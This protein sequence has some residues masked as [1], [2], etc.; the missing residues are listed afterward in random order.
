MSKVEACEKK[1][2]RAG[3]KRRPS[4]VYSVGGRDMEG[5]ETLAHD[6]WCCPAPCIPSLQH[7]VLLCPSTVLSIE[8]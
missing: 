6:Y 4:R 1:E 2:R 7:S 8:P 3:Q 5:G